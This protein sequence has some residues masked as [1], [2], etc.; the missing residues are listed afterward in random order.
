M[1]VKNT[2]TDL[3]KASAITKRK[4]FVSFKK[5]PAGTYQTNEF[6]IKT[7]VITE[8]NLK[9]YEVKGF[10][11]NPYT[12]G[13]CYV[14]DNNIIS[15]A[16]LIVLQDE[17]A[18]LYLV[19][20]EEGRVLNPTHTWGKINLTTLSNYMFIKESPIDY[21]MNNE[22]LFEI[23]TTLTS[24][25][26]VGPNIEGLIFEG[27]KLTYKDSLYQ[28]DI[29]EKEMRYEELL[30]EEDEFEKTPDLDGLI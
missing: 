20:N 28:R 27:Y 21:N 15:N 12:L 7:Q 29:S 26:A 24:F 9:R 11:G 4:S 3:T 19:S 30:Y 6:V 23:D 5:V 10:V 17:S 8:K 16:N 14:K 13:F 22:Y 18:N 25:K 1:F 2:S